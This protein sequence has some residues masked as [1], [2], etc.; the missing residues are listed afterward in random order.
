[1]ATGDWCTPLDSKQQYLLHASFATVWHE[2]IDTG[3]YANLFIFCLMCQGIRDACAE[4]AFFYRYCCVA[5]FRVAEKYVSV[6]K[7]IGESGKT[8]VR[9]SRCSWNSTTS[10]SSL[11]WWT[12]RWMRL[13]KTPWTLTFADDIVI[14]REKREVELCPGWRRD[15]CEWAGG[16]VRLQGEEVK[17]VEYFSILEDQKSVCH[18]ERKCYIFGR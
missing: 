3:L 1:M 4:I 14:C 15:A 5:K 7:G 17:E 12:G 10:S 11:W 2:N 13:D 18:R 8:V 9:R 6:V 16:T